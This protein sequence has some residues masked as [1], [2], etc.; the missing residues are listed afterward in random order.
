M[1]NVERLIRE[2]VQTRKRIGRNIKHRKVLKD[3]EL[4]I[5]TL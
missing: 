4:D 1:S 5:S 3:W 2:E